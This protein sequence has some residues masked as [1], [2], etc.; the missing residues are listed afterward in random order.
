MALVAV[1]TVGYS[2]LEP[3]YTVFDALYMTVITLTTVGYEEV[4]PLSTAGR[5]FTIFLLLGGVMTFFFAT[6]E[7]IRGIVGGELRTMLGKRR[8]EQTLAAMTQHVIICGYG[9]M[10]RYICR[11]FA[12]QKVPFVLIE[13]QD[14]LLKDFQLASGVALAGDA[15][16]DDVLTKAGVA[17]ARALITVAATDADNLYITMSAR[18]LNDKLF[19]VARAEQSEAEGKLQRAGANRV[20][21]PHALGGLKM[22]HAVLRP[23]VVDFIELA[24]RTEHL[25]LQIE[26]TLVYPGS[27]LAG[28]TLRATR[29]RQDPGVIVVAIK[30]AGG[31]MLSNPS[32]DQ[33]LEAGDTLIAVGGVGQLDQLKK[34]A[35]RG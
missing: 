19:I 10:G 11:E 29:L 16:A 7:I 8:M 18:L 28:A 12:R 20:V 4:H 31:H 22:T 2:L 5:V 32:G 35:G 26:E 3:N 30:R 15:T 1:G 25:D 27:R 14:G 24:T 17:R 21:A 33:V 13:R 34:M 23:A 9:R 6:T